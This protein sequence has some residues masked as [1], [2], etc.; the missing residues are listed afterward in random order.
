MNANGK[1]CTLSQYNKGM[2]ATLY[3]I[4]SSIYIYL[5][6]NREAQIKD[7]TGELGVL[8]QN[9]EQKTINKFLTMCE[10]NF[11]G[12]LTTVGVL[13]TV[14][15]DPVTTLNI[16]YCTTLTS[17]FIVLLEFNIKKL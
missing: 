12:V 17:K 4:I 5:N 3:I 13:F 9:I 14:L 11:C 10:S 1:E 8:A 2:P 7:S 6:L 16:Q 15:E